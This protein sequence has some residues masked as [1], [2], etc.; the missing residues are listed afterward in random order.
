[1]EILYHGIKTRYAYDFPLCFP[2]ELIMSLRRYIS[3]I[4]F[5]SLINN[6]RRL[7]NMDFNKKIMSMQ[8]IDFVNYVF[9]VIFKH[10]ISHVLNSMQIRLSTFTLS[11]VHVKF[12]V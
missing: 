8:Y 12:N 4:L 5:T 11:L 1:M 2:H 9:D 7:D 3:F 10:Q 6:K